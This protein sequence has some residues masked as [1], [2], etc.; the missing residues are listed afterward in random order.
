MMRISSIAYNQDRDCIGCA[1]RDEKQISTYILSFQIA[2]QLLSRYQGKW[3]ISGNAITLLFTDLDHPLTIDYDSGIINYGSLTTA[4]YHRYNPAKGLT[5]LVEDICSDLAI[6][7]SEPIE[8]EEYF[9]RLFVKLVEIFHARC[10]VQ[11]LPGKNEGKWEIRLGEGEASGWIG[12]DG[13]AENRFG[14]KID[15]KQWQSLRI[16]K[17]ALYVFGFNSFCKNF[18]CP[19]K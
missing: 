9:F 14:E 19:I 3:G 2:D 18:Q 10:N 7:Q 5:V 8:Y 16:E 1:I 17:A 6:P 4:F 15:I 13:I 11:I 12:K